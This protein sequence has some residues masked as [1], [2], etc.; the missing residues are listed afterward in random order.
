MGTLVLNLVCRVKRTIER[1][2]NRCEGERATRHSLVIHMEMDFQ[3]DSIIDCS[4]CLYWS[5]RLEAIR[6][7]SPF[8]SEGIGEEKELLAIVREHQVEGACVRRLPYLTE[9][10]TELEENPDQLVN[11]SGPPRGNC[12]LNSEVLK[13]NFQPTARQLRHPEDKDRPTENAVGI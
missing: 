2:K 6:T 9:L 8:P 1:L 12:S 3:A 5:E 13:D 4:V 7:S 11:A 10:A